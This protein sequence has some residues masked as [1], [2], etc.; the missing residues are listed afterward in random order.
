MTG[1]STYV[2]STGDTLEGRYELQ[3]ELGEGGFARA[4]LARDTHRGR[5][6]VV[7]HPLYDR[8]SPGGNPDSLVEEKFELEVDLL[9]KIRD[10]G[11]HPHV[12][13]LEDAFT[14]RGIEFSVV[15][16]IDGEILEEVDE[17]FSADQVRR[18]GIELCEILEFLHGLEIVYRDMKPDNVMRD[19]EGN[20]AL[21]DL[22]AAKDVGAVETLDHTSFGGNQPFYPPEM[23]QSSHATNPIP[24][25]PHSDV[26]AAGKFVFWLLVG[27]APREDAK[28]PSELGVDAPAYLDEIIVRATEADP[29]DRYNNATILRRALAERDSSPAKRA[30]IT[31][32]QHPERTFDVNPG[33]TIGRTE[34]HTAAI[35]VP[36]PQRYISA[37]QAKFDVDADGTWLIEDRSTNGTFVNKG[38][39]WDRILSDEGYRRLQGENQAPAT[40]PPTRMRLDDGDV[41]ALVHP[42]EDF[43]FEFHEG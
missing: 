39:G 21:I 9:E 29:A 19:S 22:N 40:N 11:G 28:A 13:G 10:A 4:Y 6:V 24:L 26:Y 33:D 32:V 23:T 17:T 15:E 18:M 27:S 8:F 30:R 14:Y 36:D 31:W 16:Y 37:V 12:M 20:I 38:S 7:K 42:Q 34:K 35:T 2:P 5:D 25:G 1:Q 3:S 41:I 43:Y